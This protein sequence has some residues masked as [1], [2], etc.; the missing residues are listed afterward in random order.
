MTFGQ[1][2]MLFKFYINFKKNMI[3]SVFI[4]INN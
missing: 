3:Y 2:V 1:D 4:K